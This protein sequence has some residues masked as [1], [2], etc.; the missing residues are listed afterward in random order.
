MPHRRSIGKLEEKIARNYCHQHSVR[1][2]LNDPD[3]PRE[4]VF[5]GTADEV[6]AEVLAEVGE[7]RSG[8]IPDCPQG[9]VLHSNY[10]QGAFD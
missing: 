5:V 4:T 6:V 8:E 10:G 2:G 7:R 1:T 9:L 3:L